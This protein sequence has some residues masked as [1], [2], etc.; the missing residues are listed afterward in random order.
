MDT[1]CDQRPTSSNKMLCM[2]ACV[3]NVKQRKGLLQFNPRRQRFCNAT[4]FT[5]I[6]GDDRP[7][8]HA[9]QYLYLPSLSS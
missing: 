1:N 8:P 7:L 9:T 3:S 2:C 6:R 4:N 5:K